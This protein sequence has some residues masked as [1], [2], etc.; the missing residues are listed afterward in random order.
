MMGR[1]TFCMQGTNLPTHPDFSYNSFVLTH[2]YRLADCMG[3]VIYSTC[4]HDNKLVFEDT[5]FKDSDIICI[6]IHI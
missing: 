6:N 5:V 1:E 2:L 3:H 4:E